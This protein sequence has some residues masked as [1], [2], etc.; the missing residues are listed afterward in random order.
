M[1]HAHGDGQPAAALLAGNHEIASDRR[2]KW[3]EILIKQRAKLGY[4]R[5][6]Q[7]ARACIEYALGVVAASLTEQQRQEVADCQ[8][9]HRVNRESS[10]FR[11]LGFINLASAGTDIA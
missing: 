6:R 9:V 4:G 7:T 1:I 3:R 5:G 11:S 8:D 2:G 10:S